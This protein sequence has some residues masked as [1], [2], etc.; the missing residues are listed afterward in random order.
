MK[1]ILL[2][3]S[4]AG[5]L[6]LTGCNSNDDD[7]VVDTRN[8]SFVVGPISFANDITQYVYPINPV[9]GTYD[10]LLIYRLTGNSHNPNASDATW[11]LVPSTY[12]FNNGAELN[13]NTDFNTSSI[14]FYLDANFD[15][16]TVSDYALN[17]YYRIVI[18]KN[19]DN[20][21][22]ID[23]RDYNSVVKMFDVVENTT[24]A[25]K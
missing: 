16:A 19:Y 6:T 2:L 17:Q 3:F 23:V 7:V 11:E 20:S 10:T 9:L 21:A 25:A 24:R 15:L 22:R 5:L 1:K 13:Y 14:A 8:E 18:I 4:V 12:K